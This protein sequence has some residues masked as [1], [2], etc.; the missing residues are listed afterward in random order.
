MP[1]TRRHVM[2]PSKRART[3]AVVVR[4]AHRA[5]A[6]K[7]RS[8]GG[9]IL[10]ALV[11]ATL[12][13]L[14]VIAGGVGVAG[15]VAASS[16][17][18]LS[19]GL[20]DPD[21]LESISFAEPTIVYDRSGKVELARFQQQQRVVL[22]YQQIPDLVLDATTGAEDR[23][24]WSNE[25]FDVQ[26]MLSAAMET[27]NGNGRGASTITQQLVRARLLPADVVAPGSDVYIRKAKEIIQAARVT[28][29]YPGEEGKRQIIT[30]YLNQIY[31]GHDAYGIAAAA[32][33]YFGVTDLAKLTPAQAA[34]LA[35][36]PQSPSV[37]DPYRYA[38]ADKDGKLFVPQNSPP[39]QR[40]NWILGNLSAGR[41]THLT[42]A[43]IAKAQQEP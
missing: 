40:R 21:K 2:P 6:R 20:P 35:G 42:A 14:V 13:I 15:L 32:N 8:V 26:A 33:A 30:A 11:T 4:R 23:T 24:F 1:P 16:I 17:T 9:L 18:A 25:G 22:D 28:Q 12:G 38:V 39:V 3:A 37:L 27:L 7:P 29:A 10:A 43:E 31:Y 19:Q 41:W 34:L 5:P 36:L